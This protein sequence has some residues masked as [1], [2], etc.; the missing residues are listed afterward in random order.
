MGGKKSAAKE[1][2]RKK[3]A[4]FFLRQVRLLSLSS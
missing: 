3:P 2:K 4:L 1:N